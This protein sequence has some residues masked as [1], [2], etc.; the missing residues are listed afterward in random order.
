M[1]S[2][3]PL[4]LAQALIACPSVKPEDGGAQ[5]LLRDALERL[6]FAVERWKT[7]AVTNLIARIGGGTPH[8]AFAGHTDVVPPGA[9]WRH[10]PFA[11][12]IEDGVLFGRGAVDMKGAIAAF[13]AALA[14]RRLAGKPDGTVSV[15]ITGDEEADALDGT[16]RI[17]ERLAAANT[18]PDM[19]LV[20][21]PTSQA[22]LG[23]TVKIGRRGSLSARLLVEGIQGHV[24]Y[25][26]LADNPLHRLVPALE[27]LRSHVFDAGNDWFEPSSLQITSIDVGNPA[28]NLIPAQ[29]SARLNVRFN[30]AHSGAGLGRWIADT[31]QRFAPDAVCDIMIGG[32]PFLTQP[33]HF[34]A[35]ITAA[36]QRATG[37]TPKLDTGGGT[38]DARFI[39]PHCPVAEFGLV[40]R[41]MHRIDECVP[42]AELRALALAYEAIMDSVIG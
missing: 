2:A 36:I 33:G 41:T 25:P 3:D 21:E 8:F 30:N 16:R 7:G 26:H 23:D 40:G 17:L 37:V 32:E 1:I 15:L 19:C 34:T 31:V 24:A 22:V 10:E 13:V 14:A 12:V 6:G 11:A 9:H 29:A 4:P 27:S 39:A 28:G 5:A 20:G 38:S 18:M 42:V 35:Q